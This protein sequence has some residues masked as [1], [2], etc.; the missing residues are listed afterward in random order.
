MPCLEIFPDPD[1]LIQAAAD[2]VLRLGTEAIEENGI[3]TVALSGGSTPR[4]LYALLATRKWVK[5]IDW[6]RVHLFWGD[7]R[8]VPPDDPRS[9]YRMVRESL[10]DGISIP[11][12]NV[13]R[14]HGEEDP[15][16]AAAR[17]E[18]ELR[19]F[20]GSTGVDGPP[21]PGLDLV[22]L[23]MGRDGHTAS[24]FPGM[25]AVTGQASWVTA[26]FVEVVSMWRITLTPAAINA[27]KE[28]IFLVSG[29]EKAE[30]LHDVLEGPIQPQVLPAQMIKP[31]DGRLVWLVD[32]AAARFLKGGG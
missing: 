3:F 10:L 30:R 18:E 27:A 24:L 11:P 28:V 21:R 7:E 8:C 22:L 20:F 1:T 26:K 4:P 2:E 14:I 25:P 9:N 31:V 13:H 6:S 16:A 5:S 19:A 15:E 12:E 17:Y 29:A 32:G 23:G